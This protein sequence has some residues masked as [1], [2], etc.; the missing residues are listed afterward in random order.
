MIRLTRKSK[1]IVSFSSYT[2]H[3]FQQPRTRK[4]DGELAREGLTHKGQLFIVA[5]SI[6]GHPEGN[7]ASG[8]DIA[9]NII[10]EVYY[11]YPSKDVITCLAHAF[12]DANTLVN[13]L[14]HE[15][16]HKER[17]GI[18][19]TAFV[20]TSDRGYIAQ[21]GDNHVYRITE[22]KIERL[23]SDTKIVGGRQSFT[24][25]LEPKI[26]VHFNRYIALR[27]GD[28]YLLST[29]GLTKVNQTLIKKIV[30]SNT[31]SEAC[32]KL[33][34]LAKRERTKENIH[35]QIVRV[36]ATPRKQISPKRR[37]A[38]RSQRI[39]FSMSALFLLVFAATLTFYNFRGKS[40]TAQETTQPP[41]IQLKGVA[42][43]N[44]A[45]A[46]QIETANP[47]QSNLEPDQ[48]VR[49]KEN[50][51]N[52]TGRNRTFPNIRTPKPDE[53]K[54]VTKLVRDDWNLQHLKEFDYEIKED[55]IVFLATP[56]IKKALY[57]SEPLKNFRVN[58]AARV[59]KNNTGGR[60]GIIVG[61]QTMEN[62]PYEIYFLLSFFRQKEFLLQ[63]YSSFRKELV[64][65]I[66][67]T[68]D[69]IQDEFQNIQ[70]EVRCIG[71]F[72]ELHANQKQVFRWRTGEDIVEGKVGVFVSPETE[73][74]I[75]KFEVTEG[76]EFS[77]K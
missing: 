69:S 58:V 17:F 16:S 77:Q 67:V 75:S 46:E 12:E 39:W 29:D 71:P 49:E 35:I 65:R 41:P 38:L 19:C 13:E 25:G 23:T 55:K 2:Y 1:S 15:S 74:E 5:R 42:Q 24:L 18:K 22:N 14:L 60:F 62:S 8:G 32:R 20:V 11:S 68:F 52:N 4:Y 48:P 63:K 3:K 36:N 26:N 45:P 31:P 43:L 28:S 40:P 70:L 73:V 61:Y 44:S 72:I 9:V 51:R 34:H 6:N 30:L 7:K 66:P 27:A 53:Q 47:E 56:H 54:N 57:R 50:K 37:T 33:V 10:K 59:R 76:L 64:T 21:V